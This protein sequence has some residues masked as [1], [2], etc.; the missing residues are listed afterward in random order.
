MDGNASPKGDDFDRIAFKMRLHHKKKIVTMLPEE[1]LSL[2]VAGARREVRK[3]TAEASDENGGGDDESTSMDYPPAFA[4]PGWA[5]LDT[6]IEALIDAAGGSGA[7]CG[8][9]LHQRSIAAFI[10]AA[11]PSPIMTGT[12]PT[13]QS[14]LTKL[15][16]D[17]CKA[18]DDKAQ[19][20]AAREAALKR[21]G[22]DPVK[23]EDFIPLVLLVGATA[24]GIE[25]TAVQPSKRVSIDG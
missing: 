9:S 10:G 2:I 1:A 23:P 17:T 22:E 12:Q 24:D 7:S 4:I 19:Q 11:A 25:M 8:P 18:K 5:A 3:N 21:T 13:P 6:S 20:K 14:K 16:M 15:L